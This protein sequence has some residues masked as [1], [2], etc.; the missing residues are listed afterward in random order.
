MR[1]EATVDKD[2]SNTIHQY[3][4]QDNKLRTTHY[5]ASGNIVWDTHYEVDASGQTRGWRVYSADGLLYKRF[6]REQDAQGREVLRQYGSD[7]TLEHTSQKPEA[8]RN[9]VPGCLMFGCLSPVI[10]IALAFGLYCIVPYIDTDAE[11]NPAEVVGIVGIIVVGGAIVG[12]IIGFIL[13]RIWSA[14]QRTPVS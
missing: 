13:W 11:G 14:K 2:G 3:D 10:G 1:T 9:N 12:S 8:H 6:E 5:N 7:G 4:A